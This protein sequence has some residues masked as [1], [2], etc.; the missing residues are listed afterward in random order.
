MATPDKTGITW[1]YRDLDIALEECRRTVMYPTPCDLPEYLE[2]RRDY[3]ALLVR[4]GVLNPR[5]AEK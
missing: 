1:G 3:H 5:L 4:H 2:A